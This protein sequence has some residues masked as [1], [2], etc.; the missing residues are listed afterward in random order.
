VTWAAV[1]VW[2][3]CQWPSTIGP[4]DRAEE[5]VAGNHWRNMLLRR[6]VTKRPKCGSSCF[7]IFSWFIWNG[8]IFGAV[9][10]G[11]SRAW[12]SWLWSSP[13]LVHKTA[14]RCSVGARVKNSMLPDEQCRKG[15]EDKRQGCIFSWF[16]YSLTYNTQR[17]SRSTCYIF[18]LYRKARAQPLLFQT[19]IGW[20]SPNDPLGPSWPLIPFYE[21]TG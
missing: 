19:I 15:L 2:F 3:S 8:R 6:A 12:F 7:C 14:E 5:Q 17:Q 13:P 16:I 18:L 20:Q 9:N 10:Y 21:S 4:E 1:M 11:C